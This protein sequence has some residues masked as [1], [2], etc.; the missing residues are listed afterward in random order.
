MNA[1]A[2]SPSLADGFRGA[3]DASILAKA[4]HDRAN[5]TAEIQATRETR[6]LLKRAGFQRVTTNEFY[7]VPVQWD[8][9]FA[10]FQLA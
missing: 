4:D 9:E 6:D 3:R 7:L 1:T 10:R 5:G 2:Q 8:T